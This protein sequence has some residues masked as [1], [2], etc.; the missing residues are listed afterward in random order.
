[1]LHLGSDAYMNFTLFIIIKWQRFDVN[2]IKTRVKITKSKSLI[3]KGLF[4]DIFL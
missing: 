1:M 3:S 2:M 4:L